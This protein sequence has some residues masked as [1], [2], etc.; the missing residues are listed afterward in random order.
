MVTKKLE[1]LTQRKTLL[2]LKKKS[3]KQIWMQG[4]MWLFK[5]RMGFPLPFCT[6]Q[7]GNNFIVGPINILLSHAFLCCSKQWKPFLSRF[8]LSFLST[9]FF[10]FFYSRTVINTQMIL[11][12]FFFGLH[13]YV[14]SYYRQPCWF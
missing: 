13:S 5:I 10:K 7:R 3:W 2:T 6:N 12:E 9:F 1:N 11:C 14:S 8:F 4:C